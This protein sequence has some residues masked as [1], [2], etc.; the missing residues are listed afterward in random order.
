VQTAVEDFIPPSSE[1]I[2]SQIPVV[3]EEEKLEENLPIAQEVVPPIVTS[4]PVE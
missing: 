4:A 2:T 3:Q 1:I